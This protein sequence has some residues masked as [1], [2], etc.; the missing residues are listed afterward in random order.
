MEAGFDPTLPSG[1]T[2]L[3]SADCGPVAFFNAEGRFIPLKHLPME[4]AYREVLWRWVEWHGKYRHEKEEVREVPFKRYQRRFVP[5]PGAELSAIVRDGKTIIVSE[6]FV[7]DERDAE[8]FTHV[9][10]LFLELFGACDVLDAGL[11][12]VPT[13]EVRRLNWDVLPS[14]RY[15]W[16]ALQPILEPHIQRASEGNRAVIRRHLSTIADAGPTFVAVGR[17]GFAGYIIFCFP[18]RNLYL[19]ESMYYGN[20]TYVLNADWQ[21]VSKMTKAQ[22]LSQ[23]LHR[24]RIIHRNEWGGRIQRLLSPGAA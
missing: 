15:P 6:Q 12:T 21:E 20:A 18:D 19:L 16:S 17:A 14:G 8:R 1:Q 2:V 5:P 7:Y 3:P 9:V 22:I 4:T 24:D 13:I 23:S 10:N 11:N